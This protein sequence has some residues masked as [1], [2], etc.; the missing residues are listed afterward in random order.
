MG[1]AF[2]PDGRHLATVS[3]DRTTRFWPTAGW[4]DAKTYDWDVGKLLDVT[5]APDGATA[6]VSSDTGKVVLFDVD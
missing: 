5:F 1:I 6:A 3:K 4:G 2:F